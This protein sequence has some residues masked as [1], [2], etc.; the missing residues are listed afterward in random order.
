MY[1][2]I[3][4]TNCTFMIKY[5]KDCDENILNT[6]L[7][8]VENKTKKNLLVYRV[9]SQCLVLELENLYFL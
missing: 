6:L 1:G 2:D 5:I 4:H 8:F 7:L 3:C 9:F